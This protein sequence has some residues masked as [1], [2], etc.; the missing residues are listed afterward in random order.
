MESDSRL[1][2]AL[3]KYGNKFIW[4][5][6]LL[7]TLFFCYVTYLKY[8]SF[9]YYDWDF[10]SDVSVL[11]NS[12]H[13]RPLYYPFMEQNI[14]GAHL[15]LIIFLII[16]IYAL[17]AHPLTLLF[18]QSLFLGLPALPLYK[19]A[20]LRL[21]KTFSLSIAVAYLLYASVG[22]INLFETHFEIFEIFFLSYGLFYFEK[23]DFKKFMIFI[24]LAISCKENV[25]FV[26]FMF[27]IYALLRK[28]SLRWIL[29]PSF[30]GVL[31]FFMSVKVIIPHFAK[32]AKFYQEGFI[33]S[34]YYSHLGNNLSEMARTIFSRPGYIANIVFMPY[35][36]Q[37]LIHLFMSTAFLPLLSP[38]PLLITLPIL[39]QNLLSRA[40]THAQIQYQYAALLLPFIFFSLILTFQKILAREEAKRHRLTLFFVFL[41][42]VITSGFYLRAP[43][44]HLRAYINLYRVD[45]A[46]KAKDRLLSLI[47]PQ[48]SVMAT[49]QFL[50]KLADRRDLYSF[51]FV[52]T[53]YRMYTTEKYVPPENL[54]YALIDFNEP[55]MINSFFPPQA[56]SN[57][58]SFLT[59]GTW[60]VLSGF[61]DVV[62]F[63]KG[64]M[65]QKDLVSQTVSEKIDHRLNVNFNNMIELKGYDDFGCDNSLGRLLRMVYYWKRVGQVPQELW[66]HILFLDE[67]GEVAFQNWH[68]LGYRFC[69]PYFWPEDKTMKEYHYILV[70]AEIKAGRYQ[71]TMKIFNLMTGEL[72]VPQ[73]LKNITDSGWVI[74]GE[75]SVE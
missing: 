65:D 34:I 21:D 40:P 44:L 48:A 46:V 70:P 4:V 53:G 37:Y 50:P 28:R 49:F 63:K 10:A 25:S 7:Y 64:E 36:I 13:G 68:V 55:L 71:M 42:F 52:S 8:A 45:D 38:G 2:R 75:T 19:L 22:F 20:R 56:P 54:E 9:G 16:P 61:N 59:D 47:P 15:Y 18:L 30:L 66:M 72:L 58:R 14:F 39:A 51:H 23:A 60:G 32:D 31:W 43:Q 69:S 57:L 1:E 33:F 41:C 26:V 62:L 35:K 17:F 3:E 73:G 74:L 29:T 11:W 67:E 24:L 6:I 5:A 12:I 27:G